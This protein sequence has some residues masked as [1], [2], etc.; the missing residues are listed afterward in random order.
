MAMALHPC[1]GSAERSL[2]SRHLSPPRHA[3]ENPHARLYAGSRNGAV[4]HVLW[5]DCRLRPALNDNGDIAMLYLTAFTA[6]AALVYLVYAMLRPE[7]F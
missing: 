2:S 6:L 3:K 5:P 4:R 7:E 1:D